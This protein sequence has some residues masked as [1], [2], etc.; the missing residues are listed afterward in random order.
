MNSVEKYLENLVKTVPLCTLP[1]NT[2]TNQTE[3]TIFRYLTSTKFRTISLSSEL[4]KKVKAKIH[5]CVSKNKPLHLTVPF[6]GYKLWKFP[7]YPNPDWSEVFNLI[8]LRKYLT[9]IANFYNPGIILE[10]WSDEITVSKM[11]NYPQKEL[12]SYNTDFAEIIKWFSDYLPDNFQI[13]FSKIRDQISYQKFWTLADKYIEK[14]RSKWH[15]VPEKERKFR[16]KKSER[17]YK[18]DLA[19]LSERE[20][21]EILLYGALCHDAFIFGD[22]KKDTPWAFDKHM[23]ALGF[24]YTKSWGIPVMSSRSSY[25]QFW[26][27]M[28]ALIKKNKEFLPTIL[29]YQQYL[30]KKDSLQKR[31]CQYIPEQIWKFKT[32]I[33]L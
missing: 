23:I 2:K 20:K 26:I 12:D 7:T 32:Y 9:P 21:N 14:N 25:C 24:R 18:G 29:T 33:Y 19:K 5:L 8:Q 31:S 17:N 6:G 27:G 28:G 13:K 4:E 15:Q 30:T 11:N 1:N 16:L 3:Q 10:Y 22:W